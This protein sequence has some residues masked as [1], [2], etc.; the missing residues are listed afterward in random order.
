MTL[1]KTKREVLANRHSIS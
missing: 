1:S